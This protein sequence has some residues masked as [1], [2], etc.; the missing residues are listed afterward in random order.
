MQTNNTWK[1]WGPLV[2]ISALGLFMELAVIRWLSSE[3]RLFAYLKNIPLL[4]AFL[5]LAIGYA[6][7]GKLRDYKP[8]FI[9]LLFLFVVLV[10]VIGRLSSPRAF[11]YP[12]SGEEFV[13][14]AAPFSYWLQ[15]VVFLGMVVVFFVLTMLMF[16]PLG[17]ATGEEMARHKPVPAYVVNIAAS[18]LGIWAFT[19][20][21]Y[22]QVPPVIWIGLALLGVVVY[23]RLRS[24]ISPLDWGMLALILIGLGAFNGGAIWSPYQRLSYTDLILPRQGGG[25]PVKVGYTLNVQQVFFQRAVDLSPEFLESLNGDIPELE[26]L[27]YSY[28][29]PYRSGKEGGRV[30]IVGAGIGNDVAAALRNGA[31]SVDAVEIDPAILALGYQLHP[32]RPYEDQRVKAIVDD[33]RSFFET[34]QQLYDIVAFGLLDS[35]T[36][37]SSLSSVR[38]DSYVYTLESFEQVRQ[39]LAPGGVVAVTFATSQHWIDE[40]LGRMLVQVFRAERVWVHRGAMGTTFIAGDP[41]AEQ[42]AAL[43]LQTWQPDAQITNL[44]LPTDDWPYLYMRARQVPSA[45]WQALLVIGLVAFFI[46]SRSFPAALRPN[47]HFWLLGAAFLLVE[48]T[49]ITKLALLF[50]TTWLVNALAISGVLLMV[51]A[52]NLL[53][54]RGV[55]VRLRLTYALLFASLALVYFF[56][57]EVLNQLAPLLRG[58]SSVLLLSIP[59]FFSGLIFSESLRRAGEVARPLASNLSGSVFGGI[60]EYGSIWW[61]V[62]SLYI[63]A[64]IVYGLAMAAFLRGRSKGG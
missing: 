5:G 59:L 56:P 3:V 52:A 24:R 10:L 19:L 1:T 43:E 57:F 34:N 54:L 29:L 27:A 62:Q 47:W 50:G 33:A 44:P 7:V 55:R 58:I 63:V 48:F 22:L 51:L 2:L 18:L 8:T 23:Y 53:V 20:V 49:S 64:V 61:G 45:Y 32:E 13:W 26:D 39:H 42:V 46:L 9:I 31:Q 6:V 30:L 15:L 12:S 14:Y 41:A 36:L 16:I 4:A 40:R 21:S 38:L 11:A 35:H 25:E 37:L 60:L 28:N 17:Q